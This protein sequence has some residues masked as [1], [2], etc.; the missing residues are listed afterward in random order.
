[1]KTNQSFLPINNQYSRIDIEVLKNL[2]DYQPQNMDPSSIQEI[3]K[4]A[5]RL[6]LSKKI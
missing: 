3:V 6:N 4:Y 5:R 1:M 2:R